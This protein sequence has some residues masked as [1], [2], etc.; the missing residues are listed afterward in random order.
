MGRDPQRHTDGNSGRHKEDQ[1]QNP[2][3][4]ARPPFTC[5]LVTRPFLQKSVVAAI[6]GGW[7]RRRRR[8]EFRKQKWREEMGV[9]GK[10]RDR[11]IELPPVVCFRRGVNRRGQCR[12]LGVWVRTRALTGIGMESDWGISGFKTLGEEGRRRREENPHGRCLFK[13]EQVG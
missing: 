10:R 12:F 4:L 13:N 7:Q 1:S 3:E 6:V 11:S 5:P 9:P 8:H 2:E